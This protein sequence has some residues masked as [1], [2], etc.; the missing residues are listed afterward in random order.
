MV[1]QKKARLNL[2]ID[3]QT[4]DFAKK[5]SYVTGVP[6]SKMLEGYLQAQEERMKGV[7]PFQWLTDPVSTGVTAEQ[8]K[9]EVETYLKNP[10]EAEFCRQNPDH[11][12]AK[13]RL[14]LLEEY[15]RSHGEEMERRKTQ[16]REFITRWM[17]VFPIS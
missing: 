16:E 8:G 2:Y 13:L 4:L 1:N 6:I 5:W 9:D 11:P 7:S 14:R 10:E 3:R 15:E 17:K 12:R